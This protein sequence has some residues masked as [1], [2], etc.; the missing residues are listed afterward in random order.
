[1]KSDGNGKTSPT[2]TDGGSRSLLTIVVAVLILL[3]LIACA[4]FGLGGPLS[5]DLI[6]FDGQV[7]AEPSA[8]PS[9]PSQDAYQPPPEELAT[10]TLS[11]LAAA[12]AWLGSP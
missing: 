12:S 5:L 6:S 11:P 8:L 1:M 2:G 9:P 3:A 7:P 4:A 10:P